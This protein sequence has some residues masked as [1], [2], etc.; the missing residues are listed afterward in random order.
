MIKPQL[1]AV[2]EFC[3][4]PL[5][6]VPLEALGQELEAQLGRLKAKVLMHKQREV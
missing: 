4:H 2:R 5:V 3:S 1:H 6:Q